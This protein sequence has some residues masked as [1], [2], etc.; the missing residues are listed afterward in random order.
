MWTEGEA[1]RHDDANSRFSQFCEPAY[2]VPLEQILLEVS[3]FLLSNSVHQCFIL[4]IYMLLLPKGRTGKT[5]N[6][7]KSYALSGSGSIG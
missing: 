3:V 5:E 7:P 2:K 1:R 6:L 4:T